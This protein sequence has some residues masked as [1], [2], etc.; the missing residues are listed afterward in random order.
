MTSMMAERRLRSLQQP[1]LRESGL[2]K[3]NE[4]QGDERGD[5]GRDYV[6][7]NEKSSG[8]SGEG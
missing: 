3:E 4:E 2:V 1:L 8:V 5:E 7:E 6:E